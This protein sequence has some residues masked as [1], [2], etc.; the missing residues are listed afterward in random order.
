MPYYSKRFT[1]SKNKKEVPVRISPAT[2]NILGLTQCESLII[3]H[4]SRQSYNISQLAKVTKIPRTSLYTSL[5]NLH[6]RGLIHPKKKGV[7]VSFSKIDS[8]TVQQLYMKAFADLS[9]SLSSNATRSNTDEYFITKQSKT[10]PQKGDKTGFTM[11][12]G[13]DALIEGWKDI[14]ATKQSRV[15]AIQPT[16]VLIDILTAVKP[17]KIIPINNMIKDKEIIMDAIVQENTMSTYMNMFKNSPQLQTDI[18]KSLE[19]RSADF[20]LV[21]NKYLNCH[22]ELIIGA[23][24]ALIL[25]W[26]KEMGI[27]IKNEGMIELLRELFELAKGYG[28]KTDFTKHVKKYLPL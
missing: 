18:I 12:N 27:E 14:T 16:K 22:S 13:S 4:L 19:G 26:R 11:L 9:Y 1:S 20:T 24:S 10:K 28:K 7:S 3:R 8:D 2:R 15:R 5:K 21:E 25:D 17:E 6:K 23:R